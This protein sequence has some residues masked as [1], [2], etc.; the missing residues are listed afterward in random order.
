[1]IIEDKSMTMTTK[2]KAE[3]Y[4]RLDEPKLEPK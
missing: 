1:M 3:K 4:N 2:K